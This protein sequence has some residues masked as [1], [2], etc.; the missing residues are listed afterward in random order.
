MTV[1][2]LDA[3]LGFYCDRLGLTLRLRRTTPGGEVAFLDAGGGQLEIVCPAAAVS[4][5]ARRVGAGEAGLR[6][7]TFAVEDV[8]ATFARLTADGVPALEAPRD[9]HNRVVFTRG[10]LRAR[11]GRHRRGTRRARP[12]AGYIRRSTISFLISA[13]ALAGLRCFGQ[14]CAQFMIVWQR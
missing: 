11:P 8:D 6:H 7:L 1:S 3:S 4:T 13:I 14:V 5:P 9:A 10:R 12:A 2:D